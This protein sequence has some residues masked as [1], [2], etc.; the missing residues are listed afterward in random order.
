[1]DCAL[2]PLLLALRHREVD[3]AF[4]HALVPFV[5]PLR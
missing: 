3:T 1:M 2:A 5:E 4:A